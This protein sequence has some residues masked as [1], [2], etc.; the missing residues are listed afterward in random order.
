MISSSYRKSAGYGG[1]QA[2]ARLADELNRKGQN[3]IIQVIL[4]AA[5]CLQNRTLRLYLENQ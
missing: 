5:A 3:G 1:A 2:V 4:L